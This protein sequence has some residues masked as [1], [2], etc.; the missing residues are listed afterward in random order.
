MSLDLGNG[1]YGTV[2]DSCAVGMSLHIVF[3]P[4]VDAPRFFVWGEG[5]ADCALGT[6]GA[7]NAPVTMSALMGVRAVT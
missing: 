6:A 1:E 3:L 5:A 2:A 4:E 7:R